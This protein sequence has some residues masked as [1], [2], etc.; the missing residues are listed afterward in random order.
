VLLAGFSWLVWEAGKVVR[1]A[2]KGQERYMRPSTLA[3][4]A[5][6]ATACAHGPGSGADAELARLEQRQTDFLAALAAR[7]VEQT[8]AHFAEDAVLQVANM[9]PVQG[10]S[11][12]RQF[13]GNVFRFMAASESTPEILRIAS[14]GDMADTTGRVANTFRGGQGPVQYAGKY[15][16]VWEKRSGEWSIVVY[17]ISNNQSDASR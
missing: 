11:A 17:S 5:V 13:Y 16:L 10:R 6:L 4:L 12:I 9:P 3:L 14:G 8:A 1:K 15:L 7:D 2:L